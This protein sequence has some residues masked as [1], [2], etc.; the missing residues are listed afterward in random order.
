MALDYT[1]L[2]KVANRLFVDPIGDLINNN[3]PMLRAINKLNLSSDKIYMRAAES[4]PTFGGAVADGSDITFDGGEGT[5]Y[6]NPTLEWATY[7]EPFKVNA[8][9]LAQLQSSET[10]LFKFLEFE[11]KQAANNL[12]NKIASDVFAGTVA[13]GIVG[14]QTMIDDANT[15]AGINRATAENWR[16]AVYSNSPDDLVGGELST[17]T[18]YK[19]DELYFDLNG[20]GI[21]ERANIFTGVTDSKILNKYKGLMETI[22]YGSLSTAHFVNQANGTNNLG[23]GNVGFAGMPII[24]DRNISVSGTDLADTSRLYVLN[25]NE[26]YLC[27]LSPNPDLAQYHQ[28]MGMLSGEQSGSLNVQVKF[29]APTGENLKGYVCWYGQ[30]ATMNPKKAGGVITNILNV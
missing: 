28:A 29:L 20:E 21:T 2:S 12:A 10:A 23:Y 19:L 11:I 1:E 7:T 8:R 26:I 17:D 9:A 24:R 6:I 25:M 13:N 4:R 30:L 15:Y 3:N 14:L 5:N 18:F 16:S 22:D 27:Q